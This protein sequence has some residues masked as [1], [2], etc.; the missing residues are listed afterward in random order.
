EPLRLEPVL[1][2]TV[3][4]DDRLAARQVRDLAQAPC[5]RHAQ[6]QPGCLAERLF[7][8]KARRQVAQPALRPAGTAGFPDLQLRVAQD[9][10]RKTFA[11]PLQRRADAAHVADVRSDA[12]DHEPGPVPAARAM[13]ARYA[14]TV[15]AY[16]SSRASAISACPIETSRTPGTARRK[17]VKFSRL[18][19]WPA[20]TSKPAAWAARAA[21]ANLR[22]TSSWRSV[23]Q[24]RA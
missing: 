24:A 20:L 4:D 18:R 17:S 19:S 11:V 16:P 2:P 12:V 15:D 3:Q 8:G 23:P 1:E 5:H 10:A 22:S 6:S 21:S 7:G 14:S 13:Q 9:L